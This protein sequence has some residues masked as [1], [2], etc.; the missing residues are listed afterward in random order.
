[1][2]RPLHLRAASHASGI[3]TT[4]VE[5]GGTLRVVV[6]PKAWRS[7]SPRVRVDWS[8]LADERQLL[9]HENDRVSIDGA[10]PAWRAAVHDLLQACAVESEQASPSGGHRRAER[11]LLC[12]AGQGS[13]AARPVG[14]DDP[15]SVSPLVDLLL[16]HHHTLQGRR[17]GVARRRDPR[18]A[19][20]AHAAFLAA[21]R[22]ALP[23]LRR[24]YVPTTAQLGAVRGAVDPGRSAGALAA[25]APRLEC[26]FDRFTDHTPLLQIVVTALDVVAATPPDRLSAALRD[27][28]SP[29]APA[30]SSEARALRGVL[31]GVPSI[32]LASARARVGHL[33][34][35]ASDRPIWGPVV[36]GAM[37]VLWQRGPDLG[38]SGSA[39]GPQVWTLDTAAAWERILAGA[40]KFGF[41]DGHIEHGRPVSAPWPLPGLDQREA[42]LW[43]EAGDRRW[44]L[45]AKY[46]LRPSP[47]PEHLNQIYAYSRL[48]PDAPR[49]TGLV[50]AR[51]ARGLVAAV[52]Q[53]GLVGV[54]DPHGRLDLHV[55][56]ADFPPRAVLAPERWLPWCSSLGAALAHSLLAAADR[57]A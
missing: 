8:A 39:D 48:D 44:L 4:P 28:L 12:P 36:E 27:H 19:A 34:I 23:W 1:M 14:V 57:A 52:E 6:M 45:D 31:Q 13:G 50:Y 35:S 24:G 17:T 54:S 40:L 46:S 20:M 26:R 21:T 9:L 53:R 18:L 41:S 55:L 51:A 49:D 11:V 2:N 47:R 5:G 32:P 10:A 16:L 37:D 3:A 43:V 56:H 38:A 7:G 42:D 25:G 29:G 33:H 30:P 15:E 22:T